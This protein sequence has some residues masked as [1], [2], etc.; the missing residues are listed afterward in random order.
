MKV[1]QA[2]PKGIHLD[3]PTLSPQVFSKICTAPVGAK[4]L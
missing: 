2:F 3:K 1:A 4:A